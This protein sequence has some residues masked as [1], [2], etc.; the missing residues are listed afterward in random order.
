MPAVSDDLLLL[1]D[2]TFFVVPPP[3]GS[4]RTVTA[5]YV[6]HVPDSGSLPFTG[7]GRVRAAHADATIDR[8]RSAIGERGRGWAT[9]WISDR[10]TPADLASRLE[11]RGATPIDAPG[12]EAMYTAM[13]L[14]DEPEHRGGDVIARRV[15]TPEEYVAATAIL[16]C[17]EQVSEE[18]RSRW[19]EGFEAL[20]LSGIRTTYLA[21]IGGEPVGMAAMT[22]VPEGAALTGSATLPAH[23]GRGVYRAL[24]EARWRDAAAAGARGLVVQAGAMSRPVLERVGFTP[25]G[26]VRVLVDRFGT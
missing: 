6:M 20:H 13:A 12:I 4:N 5:E 1:A 16:T 14:V 22:L 8:V 10:T 18:Q 17:D 21:W 2:E 7:V 3:P 23:R 24:I 26:T 11:A 25:V 9:W 15:E 19:P